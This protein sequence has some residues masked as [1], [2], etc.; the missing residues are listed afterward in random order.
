MVGPRDVLEPPPVRKRRDFVTAN[1]ACTR[2]WVNRDTLNRIEVNRARISNY[3]YRII[4]SN[5]FIVLENEYRNV[6]N[7]LCVI[8][9]IFSC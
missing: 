3:V 7:V 6:V 5:M 1:F 8:L 4:I 9:E 2:I